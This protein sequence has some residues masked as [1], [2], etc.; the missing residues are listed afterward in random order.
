MEKLLKNT[1]ETLS[2]GPA[3]HR[4][5]VTVFP[6]VGTD[7]AGPEYL[8]L[9]EALEAALVE[10]TEVGP[11]GRVPELKVVNRSDR[12]VLLLDGEEL[13]GAKQ[14]RVLNTSVLLKERS[15]TLIPVSCTEQGRWSWQQPGF[16]DSGYVMSSRLRGVKNTSV[17]DSL[18]A[19]G[20]YGSDQGAVWS[21]IH[22]LH[23]RA[24]VHSPTG[25]LRDAYEAK[26]ESL[27]QWL[28]HFPPL[29]GQN[30]LLVFRGNRAAGMD[31]VSSPGAYAR[32]HDK[33][34]RSYLVDPLLEAA[35]TE[36][37]TPP[38][39]VKAFLR[40]ARS[41]ETRSFPSVGYG[42][43]LRCRGPRLVGSAL[44]HDGTVVHLAFFRLEEGAA[45]AHYP[46][47]SQRRGFRA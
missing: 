45:A 21:E 31:R 9:A 40:D 3:Q 33:L 27:D 11:G 32:L 12:P 10:I 18:R 22:A 14:N 5:G 35:P 7:G 8:T 19:H 6:L 46:S 13:R 1:L 34:V 44:V 39:R 4:G 17:G 16:S 28:A 25:A 29:P 42:A 26:R 38:E 37:A 23:H 43:D 47:F 30:G 41:C 15:E 20:G 2:F 24:N 36:G